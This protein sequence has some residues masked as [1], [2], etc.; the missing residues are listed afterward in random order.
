MHGSIDG[1]APRTVESCHGP[2]PLRPQIDG[3][4]LGPRYLGPNCGTLRSFASAQR[5]KLGDRKNDA[6]AESIILKIRC[7]PVETAQAISVRLRTGAACVG[8]ALKIEPRKIGSLQHPQLSSRLF[9]HGALLYHC[10]IRCRVQCRRGLFGW[11]LNKTARDDGNLRWIGP[12]ELRESR[13]RHVDRLLGLNQLCARSSQFGFR[14][15]LVGSRPQLRVHLRGNGL[16]DNIPT[17]HTRLG[18]AHRLLSGNECQISIDGG[19]G[20]FELRFLSCG[21]RLRPCRAR[22]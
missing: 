21:F 9:D 10:R 12:D 8:G 15:R 17:I 6:E 22:D 16:D 7:E 13:T 11:Q 1:D 20:Y 5:R 14:A 19:D 18:G 3:D 2:V 4:L